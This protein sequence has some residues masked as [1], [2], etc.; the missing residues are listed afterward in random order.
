M[1]LAICFLPFVIRTVDECS[2]LF[3]FLFLFLCS[4]CF[5]ACRLEVTV[6]SVSLPPFV[7]RR[8]LSN[9]NQRLSQTNK[10][11][12]SRLNLDSACSRARCCGTS[13][14]SVARPDVDN[15]PNNNNTDDQPLFG[16]DHQTSVPPLTDDG[17]RFYCL[18]LALLDAIS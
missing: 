2:L 16:R 7:S 14:D 13:K 10:H 15:G 4:S 18:I 1:G 12:L 8:G 17:A 11:T 5:C 6:T 9:T 3:S